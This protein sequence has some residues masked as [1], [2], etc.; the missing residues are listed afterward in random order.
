MDA[1]KFLEMMIQV[2]RYC[3]GILCFNSIL[4]LLNITDNH[5]YITIIVHCYCS[6]TTIGNK[7]VCLISFVLTANVVRWADN[8]HSKLCSVYGRN[9]HANPMLCHYVLQF[10]IRQSVLCWCDE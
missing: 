4:T 3:W 1:A 6:S 8:S 5:E 7:I 10:V 2:T 9:L